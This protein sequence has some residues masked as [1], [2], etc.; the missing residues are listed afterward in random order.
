[1]LPAYVQ[2][3]ALDEEFYHRH[4]RHRLPAKMLD[5]HQH[6]L[7]REFLAN[8]DPQVRQVDWAAQCYEE[9]TL[10]DSQTFASLLFPDAVYERNALTV[11]G[12]GADLR[13]ANAYLA[14]LLRQGRL[15]YAMMTL[16]PRWSDAETEKMLVEG[17]FTGFKPYPDLVT[18]QKASEVSIFACIPPSKLEILNRH[19]KAMTL[20]I[21][22]AGRLADVRNTDEI[23]RIHDEYPNVRMIIAHLGRSYAIDVFAKGV[24]LLGDYMHELTFDLSAVLNPA[25]LDMALAT[26]RPDK[27]LWGTDLPV[28]MWHGRRRWTNTA[29]FNLAREDFPWNHHEEGPEAEAGYTFFLYEQVNNILDAI[30]RAG[31]GKDLA[32]AIFYQNAKTLLE[33]ARNEEGALC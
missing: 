23:K 30:D 13:A 18:G 9:M 3:T 12:K 16:D 4:L 14:D 7:K 20:H 25:V 8:L 17:G 21:P 10:E 31:G 22:R 32:N 28:F 27:L 15:R 6:I 24:E 33:A 1:M 19:K 2:R 11:V 26:I 29:Y 5:V